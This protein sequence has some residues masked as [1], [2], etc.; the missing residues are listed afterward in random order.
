MNLYTVNVDI[1]ASISLCEIMKMGNFACIKIHVLSISGSFIKVIFEGY[2]F[3]RIFKKWE[4]REN[5]YS[6]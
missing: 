2:I 3:S 5:M 1:F 4:L 6:A